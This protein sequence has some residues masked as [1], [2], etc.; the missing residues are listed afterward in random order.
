MRG[1]PAKLIAALAVATLLGGPASARSLTVRSD[2]DDETSRPDIRKVWTDETPTRF[3]VR[4]GAWQ[5]L[6]QRD[7]GFWVALDTRSSRKFD[8][9]IDIEAGT[10]TVWRLVRGSPDRF[11]GR[12][13]A[14]RPD[15]RSVACDLPK[16]WFRG[17]KT[18]RFLVVASRLVNPDRAP[19]GNLYRGF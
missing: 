14:S 19:N 17:G 8:R 16:S 12:R 7:G 6:R 3:F 13:D 2:P 4:I 10:C 9:L 15:R 11:I 5:R 1:L 18:V